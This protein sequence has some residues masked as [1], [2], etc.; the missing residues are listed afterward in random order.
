MHIISNYLSVKQDFYLCIPR[1]A[2][3]HI[4]V[5]CQTENTGEVFLFF[6]Y[7]CTLFVL[8]NVCCL[9][10]KCLKL[11]VFLAYLQVQCGYEELQPFKTCK[12]PLR[13]SNNIFSDNMETNGRPKQCYK[14]RKYK[15]SQIGQT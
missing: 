2:V 4:S 5:A 11:P 7:V 14:D 12:Q 15:Y 1:R 10:L 9:K 6:L 8:S 3:H 13:N